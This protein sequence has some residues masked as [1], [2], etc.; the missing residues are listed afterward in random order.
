MARIGSTPPHEQFR[1]LSFWHPSSTRRLLEFDCD[2]S[3][4]HFRT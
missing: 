2:R 4:A 1:R 3:S